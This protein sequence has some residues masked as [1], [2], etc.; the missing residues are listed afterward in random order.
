MCSCQK[1]E[2]TTRSIAVRSSAILPKATLFTKQARWY[3][4][5]LPQSDLPVVNLLFLEDKDKI[6]QTIKQ[7]IFRA[8][9][10]GKQIRTLVTDKALRSLEKLKNMVNHDT[11]YNQVIMLRGKNNKEN[12]KLLIKHNR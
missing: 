1:P 8:T 9:K 3:R 6:I 4:W 10:E 12:G 2:T 5:K 7:L 11:S